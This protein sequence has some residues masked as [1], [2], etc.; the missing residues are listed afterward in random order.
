[1]R[2]NRPAGKR[3]EARI[4]SP[5]HVVRSENQWT[6]HTPQQC[7]RAN[8]A[9]EH[10]NVIRSSTPRDYTGPSGLRPRPR[11]LRRGTAA[12]PPGVDGRSAGRQA[13]AE[14]TD[15]M[16]PARRPFRRECRLR[17]CAIYLYIPSVIFGLRIDRRSSS[18]PAL[19]GRRSRAIIKTASTL[20]A[21]Q[22]LRPGALR[23]AGACRGVATWNTRTTSGRRSR[24]VGVAVTAC[25]GS[26][27]VG[28]A[29]TGTATA[30]PLRTSGSRLARPKGKG[31]GR[32]E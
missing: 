17:H 7:M 25:S 9:S 14:T 6:V 15:F 2:G 19:R 31:G 13:C 1:M 20:R 32:D 3:K 5:L 16:W 30:R 10:G 26:R 23:P 28:S 27:G 18:R 12:Q 21:N 24:C 4:K 29:D 22:I 8:G 11:R